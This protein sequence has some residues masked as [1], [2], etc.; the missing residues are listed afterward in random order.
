M[1]PS[2]FEI[3]FLDRPLSSFGLMVA[4]GF[5]LAATVFQRL[6]LRDS[7]DPETDADKLSRLPVWILVGIFAG[8]R[9]FYVAVEIGQGSAV[10]QS[11]VDSPWRVIAVWEG[12]LVMYGGVVG[13][14]IGGVWCCAKHGISARRFV[15]EGMASAW[16]G[17]TIGRIGCFLV[18]DDYGRVVPERF[19]D[20]PFPITV[21]VPE[22]L[23]EHSL[24]GAAN[25]GEVLWATQIWM[26]LN[27]LWLALFAIWFLRRRKY[28]GQ[29]TL[30]LVVLYAITRG[31]I[32]F[33]RGDEVR[34]LWF[35]GA[36]STSQLISVVAAIVA[37][38]LLAKN[39]GR[40]DPALAR[41]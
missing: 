35:G 8:A 31:T 7:K 37:V 23:P 17:L 5:L 26:S 27:A 33:F 24:F 40:T 41:A 3:P 4:L 9:L 14:L 36:L 19:R 2:L 30:V 25:A 34:G 38:A 28:Y 12:G 20:L 21:H 39:R 10:G 6:G 15:D 13:G 18:G 11:Y 29:G 16:V 1:F 22:P 32:E